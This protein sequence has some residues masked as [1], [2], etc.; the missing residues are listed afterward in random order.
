MM[1]PLRKGIL[2][3]KEAFSENII[4]CIIGDYWR[5]PLAI[6]FLNNND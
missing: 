1:Y 2:A 4:G 6:L 5:I 3:K